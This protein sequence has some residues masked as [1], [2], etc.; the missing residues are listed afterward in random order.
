MRGKPI[1]KTT[2]IIT[3]FLL[4]LNLMTCAGADQDPRTD[5][6]PGKAKASHFCCNP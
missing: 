2:L 6:R 4:L 5:V 3:V 1:I